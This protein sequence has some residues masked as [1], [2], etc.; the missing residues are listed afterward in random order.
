MIRSCFYHIAF[1]LIY[2]FFSPINAQFVNISLKV[3]PEL[4]AE[5]VNNLSFGQI[6][7]NTGITNIEKGDPGMGVLSIRGFSNQRV[8]ISVFQPESLTHQN[9]GIKDVILFDLKVAAN[10]FGY[11]DVTKSFEISGS[12]NLINI[13]D[14]DGGTNVGTSKVWETLYLYIFGT[15]EVGDIANGSYEGEIFFI[16]EYE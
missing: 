14:S 2:S 5:V 11:D 9:P 16:I 15:L 10:N 1:I 13:H 8:Y 3:E 7:S 6:V 12:N 4:S